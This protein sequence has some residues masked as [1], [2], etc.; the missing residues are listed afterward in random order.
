MRNTSDV[1][2][3]LLREETGTG[4][5]GPGEPGWSFPQP[6]AFFLKIGDFVMVKFS[7]IWKSALRLRMSTYVN[8]CTHLQK[9]SVPCAVLGTRDDRSRARC[10]PD[11][12]PSAGE[13]HRLMPRRRF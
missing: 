6:H 3:F 9:L 4:A 2:A 10:G 5:A 8:I 13:G 12:K 1:A 7:V 11:V